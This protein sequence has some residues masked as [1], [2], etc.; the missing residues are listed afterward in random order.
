MNT[1]IKSKVVR[2]VAVIAFT[3][4][5]TSCAHNPSTSSGQ[6]IHACS[7]NP[8]MMKYNCSISK[9]QSA[10]ENGD[11]DAQYALGY[12][13]YYGIDTV[14]DKDT[15][16]LWI[17]RSAAQG[18]PLAKKAWSLINTGATFD[19]LHQAA[20][21]NISERQA[22]TIVQQEPADVDKMNATVPTQPITTLLPAYHPSQS[23]N[24]ANSLN[25]KNPTSTQNVSNNTTSQPDAIH[26][27]RLSSNA[28]PVVA[29]AAPQV[30]TNNT[31][32]NTNNGYT[33]QL[34]ASDKLSD[35]K[36]YIAAHQLDGKANYYQTQLNGKPWYMLT[37]G[38]YP[39]ETQAEAALQNMPINL[40][41]HHPWVK[42]VTI[43]Q[44]EVQLQKVIG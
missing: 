13:Y 14:R 36:D 34:M 28:Q 24:N 39:T 11:A 31:A 6:S 26:D 17:Q 8:Y 1:S 32:A 7:N 9:I 15:A 4:F 5:I 20:T 29:T 43:V 23:E 10:A 40:Q 41:H 37:Y 27:P 30:P 12:M 21:G 42:S 22:N 33:V 44:Q 16:E 2:G 25:A 3:T 38:Q 35:V 18:Q 19:D